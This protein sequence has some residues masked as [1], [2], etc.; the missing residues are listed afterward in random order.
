MVS[1]IMQVANGHVQLSSFVLPTMVHYNKKNHMASKRST[2]MIS[3][4]WELGGVE[5]R[6]RAA[7]RASGDIV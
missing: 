4:E 3:V 7:A 1:A 6:R 2:G 5:A